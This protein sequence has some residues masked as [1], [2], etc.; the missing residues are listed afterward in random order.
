M[1]MRSSLSAVIALV[2]AAAPVGA[3]TVPSVFGGK[4]P[5]VALSGVQFCAGTLLTRVE[6]WDGVPLDVSV[7]IPPAAMDGPFPLIV[8]LH[9]WGIGK[10]NQPF[11]AQ[12]MEGYGVR[13]YSA[14]GL[15]LPCGTPA[16]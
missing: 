14:P 5:C 10:T 6:T 1:R 16:S 2:V 8:D 13:S 7:T 3:A 15:H 12:A 11:V 4:V 9:G